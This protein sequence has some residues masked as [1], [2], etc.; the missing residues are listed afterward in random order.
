MP[1]PEEPL[2]DS[3]TRD[4]ILKRV[5]WLSKTFELQWLVDQTVFNKPNIHCLEDRA[6]AQLLIDMERARECI[7]EGVPFDEAGLIRNK[8]EALPGI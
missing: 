4:S 3:I 6:L 2:F 5:R 7:S 1:R 8:A